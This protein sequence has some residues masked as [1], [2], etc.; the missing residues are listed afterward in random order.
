L[1]GGAT[2]IALAAWPGAY[3]K[4][5]SSAPQAAPPLGF[6][7]ANLPRLAVLLAILLAGTLRLRSARAAVESRFFPHMG[8]AQSPR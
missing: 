2:L 7:L 6:A 3:Q 8:V 5:K 1:A 4:S